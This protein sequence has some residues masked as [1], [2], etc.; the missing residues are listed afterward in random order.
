MSRTTIKDVAEAAGVSTMTVSRVLNQRHDVSLETRQRVQEIIQLLGYAPNSAARSLSQGRSNTLGVVTSHIEYYGPSRTL[1]GI[2]TQIKELG[3]SMLLHLIYD[4]SRDDEMDAMRAM[5][6]Q[7][8]SAI[9]WAVAEVG[10]KRAALYESARK[11]STPIIFLNAEPQPGL[12]MLS[13]D[14]VAG[15]RAA[16]SHLLAQGF[17]RIGI[18]SGP[19]TWT[20]SVE[21][22]RGWQEAL[23]AFGLKADDRLCAEGD[24]TPAS[25]EAGMAQLLAQAPEIDAVFVCNDEMAL[26]ALQAVRNA[27]LRVPDDLGMVGY[28]DAAIAPYFDPPLSS[29]RQGLKASGARAVQ[30]LTNMRNAQNEVIPIRPTVEVLQP[31]LVIRQSSLKRGGAKS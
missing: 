29:V 31:S 7:Q 18:I 27:G 26:G 3:F 23:Q 11:L 1:V 8:V 25:G 20:A 12:L 15:A 14:N 6:S 16:T 21:R 9:V 2:E 22:L 28:D 5:L 10:F 19:L 17:R 4:P 24:W 30:M 13:I